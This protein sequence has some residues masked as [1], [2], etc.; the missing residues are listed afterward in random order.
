MILLSDVCI[1]VEI[2]FHRQAVWNVAAVLR[3][4]HGRTTMWQW[5]C[6]NAECKILYLNAALEALPVIFFVPGSQSWTHSRGPASSCPWPWGSLE[7]TWWQ[8]PMA[9]PYDPDL[10]EDSQ[11]IVCF[12]SKTLPLRSKVQ[13]N[14]LA[15]EQCW[16][17]TSRLTWHT[18]KNTSCCQF[19]EHVRWSREA[20]LWFS[21]QSKV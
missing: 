11:A 9:R 5:P 4:P 19:T 14:S 12:E 21:D 15:L 16:T 1:Q 7:P 8:D 2:C 6:T 18:C 10:D 3:T 13:W 17:P 20:G